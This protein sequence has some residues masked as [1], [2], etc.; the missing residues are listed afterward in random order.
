M[1]SGIAV[2]TVALLV[3]MCVMIYFGL[4]TLLLWKLVVE[5]SETRQTLGPPLLPTFFQNYGIP[6]AILGFAMRSSDLV[7]ISGLMLAGA[8]VLTRDTSISLHP[9]V[10]VPLLSLA[11]VSLSAIAMF[12]ALF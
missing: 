4:M 12:Y 5:G 8:I 10:E 1:A 3:T 6:L 11:I 7:V 2:G 9:S